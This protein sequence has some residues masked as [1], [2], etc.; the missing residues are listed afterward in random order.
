MIFH[1]HDEVVIDVA[2]WADNKTMLKTVCDIMRQ[3]APWAQD[4]P[5]NAEGWVGHYFKKD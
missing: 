3:P 5:L 1:V 4:L 2:P